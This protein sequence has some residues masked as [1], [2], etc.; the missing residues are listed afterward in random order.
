MGSG[1]KGDRE[2]GV[3]LSGG[4]PMPENSFI[5]VSLSYFMQEQS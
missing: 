4:S 5:K 3:D 1:M 2:N